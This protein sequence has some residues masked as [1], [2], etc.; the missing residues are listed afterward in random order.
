VPPN[1]QASVIAMPRKLRQ[2]FTQPRWDTHLGD[3]FRF[4]SFTIDTS[5]VFK[6][7]EVSPADLYHPTKWKK[8]QLRRFK[9]TTTPYP[10]FLIKNT[11]QIIIVHVFYL[12]KAFLA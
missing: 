9:K 7:K 5:C 8:E 3:H 6:R 10:H 11:S 2:P 12:S 1:N 4:S